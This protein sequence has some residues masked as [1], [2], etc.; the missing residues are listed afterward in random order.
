MAIKVLMPALSPTMSEGTINKWLVKIGDKVLA[1]DILAEIETDKATMEVEAVDEGEITHIL[2]SS[3][4]QQIKVNSIIALINGD[5]NEKIEDFN[6]LEF[7]A[8]SSETIKI[9]KEDKLNEKNNFS[10]DLKKQDNNEENKN[11]IFASPFAKKYSKENEID[12]NLIK[13]S[14]PNGRI[15]KKDFDQ[16]INKN[17]NE[18]ISIVEPSNMR[19][20]IAER[21]LKTKNEVPHFYLTIETRMDR[22]I[23]LR[24][25]INK[26]NQIKVSFNDL[27]IKACAL[28]IENN[29]E[30]NIA[31]INNKIHKYKNIDVAIAVA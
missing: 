23:S 28:A 26:S 13:G 1:G 2:N 30:T 31:W 9:K 19:K 27:I 8:T 4:N 14:G 7:N 6:N 17:K 11:M 22:I 24:N 18:N 15:I 16:I 20:I 10:S 21:T 29:P 25:K 3:P 12:L 5:K